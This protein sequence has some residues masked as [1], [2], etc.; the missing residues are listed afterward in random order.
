MLDLEKYSI[1]PPILTQMISTLEWETFEVYH[2]MAHLNMLF[3]AI[4]SFTRFPMNHYKSYTATSTRSFCDL[5]LLLPS[6]RTDIH[7]HSFFPK[8]I[9]CW[10]DLLR[11]AIMSTSLSTFKTFIYNLIVLY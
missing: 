6:Y 10:N 11:Q 7:K 4:N 5:N 1:V 2:H 9:H 8:T 3:K